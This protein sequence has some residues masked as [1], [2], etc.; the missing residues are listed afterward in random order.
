M[1]QGRRQ[2]Q[3]LFEQL[4][5]LD[6]RLIHGTEPDPEVE[7]ERAKFA[8]LRIRRQLMQLRLGQGKL[9]AEVHQGGRQYSKIGDRD[10][11]DRNHADIAS[12]GL[13]RPDLRTLQ[14]CQ[15]RLSFLEKYRARRGQRHAAIAALQQPHAEL[16]FQALDLRG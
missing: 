10:E 6:V 7:P 14:A 15:H 11:A 12:P 8:N 16:L 5:E 2:N 13:L 4:L 3:F 9:R 1:S